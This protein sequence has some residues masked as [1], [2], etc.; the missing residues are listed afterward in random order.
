LI[1]LH[2]DQTNN[3]FPA[4]TLAASYDF[5]NINLVHGLVERFRGDLKI[6]TQS[7]ALTHVLGKGVETRQGIAWQYTAPMSENIPVIVI[8]RWF[9][10]YNVE[11]TDMSRTLGHFLVIGDNRTGL[12]RKQR[13]EADSSPQRM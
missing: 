11:A 2:P 6:V 13:H 8:L 9:E 10:Q 12:N 7:P 5:G 4:R 3:G 1:G